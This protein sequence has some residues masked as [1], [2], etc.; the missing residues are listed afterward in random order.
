MP[1][2]P[3]RSIL[4]GIMGALVV[5]DQVTKSAAIAS[6][7]GQLPSSHWGGLFRLEYAENPGA[8]LSLGAFL[9]DHVRFWLLSVGVGV[10]LL[11]ASYQLFANSELTRSMR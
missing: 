3:R 9:P 8:F 10:F 7:K 5:L 1:L 2:E 6:L 11:A 4:F